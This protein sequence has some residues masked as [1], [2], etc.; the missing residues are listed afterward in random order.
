MHHHSPYSSSSAAFPPQLRTA[1]GT[2]AGGASFKLEDIGGDNDEPR[3][4][5]P[6]ALTGRHVR[7]GTG[8]SPRTLEIL[9]KKLL[10][11]LK[12]KELLGENSH[13]YFGA[14]NKQK[15]GNSAAAAKHKM[16]KK[17]LF[18]ALKFSN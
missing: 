18:E 17:Q 5:A 8:A 4:R 7:P 14:L 2:S 9:R 10:E 6:R 12:L 13:L 16:E 3:R 15:N 1:Q 11:R